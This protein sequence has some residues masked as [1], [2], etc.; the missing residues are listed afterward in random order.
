MRYHNHLRLDKINTWEN[1]PANKISTNMAMSVQYTLRAFF[2]DLLLQCALYPSHNAAPYSNVYT[3]GG[4]QHCVYWK[5]K[6]DKTHF[7]NHMSYFSCALTSAGD[8]SCYHYCKWIHI[9][10]CTHA[11]YDTRYMKCT[12]LFINWQKTKGIDMGMSI[13]NLEVIHSKLV[14]RLW[15]LSYAE[16]DR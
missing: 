14:V 1:V 9:D 4:S 7:V 2:H 11:S 5:R 8:K 6:P 16:L 3:Y 13:I 15:R 12:K 10:R